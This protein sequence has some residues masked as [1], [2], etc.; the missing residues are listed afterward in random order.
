MADSA[1]LE[2]KL[3]NQRVGRSPL[4]EIDLIGENFGRLLEDALRP[5]LKTNIGALILDCD[6]TKMSTVSEN[7]PV[8][9]M[10]GIVE[11]ESSEH[12]ALVNVSSDL[13]YHIID[14]RMGG[15]PTQPAMPTTRSFTGIDVTLC[16]DFFDVVLTS[17][18]KA[19]EESLGVPV[20]ERLI[21]AGH[22]QDITTV[23]IAPK[24]ADVLQLSVS[25]DIGEAARSGDFDFVLPLSVLDVF[26][27]ATMAAEDTM[28]YIARDH[29]H[30]HMRDSV[31]GASMPLT[32]VLNRLKMP[33]ATI[34]RMKEGDI[35]PITAETPLGVDL[36]I[37]L[38]APEE[39]SLCKARLGG[40]EDM[41]VVKLKDAPNPLV[42]TY[43]Q[44]SIYNKP[45]ERNA[46]KTQPL[47]PPG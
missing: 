46:K 12:M 24:T 2:R 36:V 29:W 9:A 10:L 44:K 45:I 4:P 18:I 13:V 7:I 47:P 16:M 31:S 32:A 30:Q 39:Y 6:I 11:V 8:P 38:G 33:L 22:K 23:R 17:F 42:V 35:L 40:F 20:D 34:E 41:K 14:M 3:S 19:V 25:L 5:L 26:R 37:G 21:V 27:A 43:L 1:V 28:L 15:D